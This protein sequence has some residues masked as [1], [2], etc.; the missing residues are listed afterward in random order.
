MYLE[1][2]ELYHKYIIY[3]T[4]RLKI[5]IEKNFSFFGTYSPKL[6]YTQDRM[7]GCNGYI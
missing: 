2:L 4:L 5:A 1:P 3:T 6:D 7:H